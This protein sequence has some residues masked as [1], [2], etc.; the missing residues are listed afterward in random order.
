VHKS[1]VA[2]LLFASATVLLSVA[3]AFSLHAEAA[4]AAYS[5]FSSLVT[6]LFVP[7]IVSAVSLLEYNRSHKRVF[8][9]VGLTFL[10]IAFVFNSLYIWFVFIMTRGGNSKLN[11]SVSQLVYMAPLCYL[12]LLIISRLLLKKQRRV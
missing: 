1:S 9:Y 2:Q 6:I 5:N 8:L 12:I 4:K 3:Y 10:A 11:T 7:A